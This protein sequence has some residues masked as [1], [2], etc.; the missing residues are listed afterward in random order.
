MFGF[1]ILIVQL[2]AHLIEENNY[3]SQRKVLR[4]KVSRFVAQINN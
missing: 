2:D 4:S 1:H 3:Q